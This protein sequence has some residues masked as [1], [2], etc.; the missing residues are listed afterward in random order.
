MSPLRQGQAQIDRA[1]VDDEPVLMPGVVS[2]F[3]ASLQP[4]TAPIGEVLRMALLA[5]AK[6][7]F[8]RSRARGIGIEPEGTDGGEQGR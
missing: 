5:L 8:A 4:I 1:I 3:S 7:W 2:G 6:P